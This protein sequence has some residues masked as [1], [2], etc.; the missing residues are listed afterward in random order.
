MILI[1][2]RV[3]SMPT[4][5]RPLTSPRRFLGRT[6]TMART[7]TVAVTLALAVAAP[8][9]ACSSPG[10]TR[11]AAEQTTSRLPVAAAFYPLEF[12]LSQVGGPGVDVHTLTKPGV[13]PHDL[14]LTAKDIADLPKM[15]LVASA[16]GS[17]PAADAPA[18]QAAAGPAYDVG[19][20]AGLGASAPATSP[21][22]PSGSVDEE[23][24]HE[25]NLHFWLDPIR[26][27]AV[28]TALADRLASIDPA[29][30]ATYR[31]NA[32]RFATSMGELDQAYA[33]GLKT[34][35]TRTLVTGHAA[36]G[37]LAER[38]GL[39]ELPIAGLS[40]DQE[41]SPRELA[42]IAAT[43]REQ[44][45]TT[46]FAETLVDPKFAQT[47]A[48]ETGAQVAV[49][50]PVEGITSTSPGQDYRSVMLANLTSLRTGLGCS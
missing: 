33:A 39:T 22:R 11:E 3:P 12:V 25:G 31:A 34:C 5:R 50:D 9:A 27:A 14:E 45:V 23:H 19:A 43:A 10:A 21:V 35:R 42:D 17:Q 18:A 36:F 7:T 26:N 44:G 32:A 16:A 4:P 37:F 46:V 49:L 47:I 8:L 20:A 6:T 40:P 2:A 29:N 48:R 15:G 1:S 24:G 28:G 13:G 41:P 38:Y 30:A